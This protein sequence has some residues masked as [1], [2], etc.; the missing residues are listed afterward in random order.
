MGLAVL[1]RDASIAIRTAIVSLRRL[2]R[3]SCCNWCPDAP[4]VSSIQPEPLISEAVVFGY[5]WHQVGRR[6]DFDANALRLLIH[7]L[8]HLAL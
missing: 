6:G 4:C 1:P 7:L 2:L 3:S 5:L 8:W